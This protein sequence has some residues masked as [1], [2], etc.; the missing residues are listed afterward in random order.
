MYLR[1][2]QGFTLVEIAIVLVIIGLLLGGILKVHELLTSARVR[3]LVARQDGIK[4]AFFAFEERFRTAR[5]ITRKPR[6]TSGAQPRTA[7]G[8]AE[9]R[10]PR[11][12]TSPSWLGGI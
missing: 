10:A 11:F 1:K 9:L 4:A 12:R 3:E 8:M 2:T 7:T 5:A 6:S